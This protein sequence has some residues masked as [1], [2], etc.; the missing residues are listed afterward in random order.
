M[1]PSL[2]FIS[3]IGSGSVGPQLC[4]MGVSVVVSFFIRVVAVHLHDFLRG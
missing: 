3:K 1:I 4:Q 2:S